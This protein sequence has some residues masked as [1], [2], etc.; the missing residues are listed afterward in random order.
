MK[1]IQ[2]LN[3]KTKAKLVQVPMVK[4]KGNEV[5]VKTLFTPI[6]PTD[7]EIEKLK[8]PW[9]LGLEGSGVIIEAKNQDLIG[10]RCAFYKYNGTFAEYVIPTNYFLLPDDL[11]SEDA[12]LMNIIPVSALALYKLTLGQRFILSGANSSLGQLLLTLTKNQKPICIVRNQE[13][14]QK[15]MIQGVSHVIDFTRG[16][17]YEYLNL[18]VKDYPVFIGFDLVAGKMTSTLLGLLGDGGVLYQVGNLSK[19]AIESVDYQDLIHRNKSLK[20]FNFLNYEGKIEEF[21]KEILNEP[22]MFRSKIVKTLKFEDF[23]QGF[24]EYNQNMRAGKILLNFNDVGCNN[25]LQISERILK[26]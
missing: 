16:S 25:N 23:G 4:I 13:G 21:Y 6:H 19:K 9:T 11:S 1:A 22:F 15:L 3:A 24:I 18:C 2:V 10:K 17:F 12:S 8:Y 14:R 20:G 5:L 26:K 7:L